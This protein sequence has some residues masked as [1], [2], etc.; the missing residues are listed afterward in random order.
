[1]ISFL[2]HL[3]CEHVVI[4]SDELICGLDDVVS[5]S[6]IRVSCALLDVELNVV[7]FSELDVVYEVDEVAM[8]DVGIIRFRISQSLSSA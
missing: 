7:V 3:S 4:I 5:F 6:N 8:V 2:E 1:M